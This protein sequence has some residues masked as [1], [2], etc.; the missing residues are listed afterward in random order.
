[1][2]FSR[3]LSFL[4]PLF[5]AVIAVLISIYQTNFY[6]FI[7]IIL[8][9][10]IFTVW[11]FLNLAAKA[12]IGY[13]LF[14]IW[15]LFGILVGFFGLLILLENSWALN[16]LS[17]CLGAMLYYFYSNLFFYLFRKRSVLEKDGELAFNF[18]EVILVFVFITAVFG[19]QD[20]LNYSLWWTVLIFVLFFYFGSITRL[21]VLNREKLKINLIKALPA[22]IIFTELAFVFWL[23]PLV[24]Y[25]KSA[26]FLI[27]YTI[28]ASFYYQRIGKVFSASRKRF[29]LII[30]GVIVLLLLSFARWF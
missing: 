14:S 25:V 28:F 22:T 20:F 24:Y 8:A 15:R 26:L 13:V 6:Y 1:M 3:I 17:V 4:T 12:E 23:L 29:Y 30:G 9:F 10:N 2:L 18:S 7:V 27:I 16:L 11:R 21:L 5:T 19:S